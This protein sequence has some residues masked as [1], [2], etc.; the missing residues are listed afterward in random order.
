M[1]CGRRV[2]S[3]KHFAWV[4]LLL[5]AS[6]AAGD[7]FPVPALPWSPLRYVCARAPQAPTIDGRLDDP[8][9]REAAWTDP[10][11]D[12]EGAVRPDPRFLTRARMLWD[13]RYFY[14]AAE[15]E[16]PHVWGTLTERDAVIFRDN[17]FEVFLDPDGDTHEYYE[18]EINALG[19]EWDL[20]LIR[21]YR[22]GGPAVNAWDIQGLQTAVFIDGTINQPGDTDRGWSVEIAFPW[23]VLGQCAHRPAPPE[24]GDQWRVNFSRVEWDV[25]IRRGAYVKVV[26]E[27]TGEP[28]PEHNWVWSPQG[29]I[30][31][32]YPEMWGFVQFSDRADA[33]WIER[34]RPQ[35]AWQL[36]RAYYRQRQH[37]RDHGRYAGDLEALGLRAPAGWSY[38]WPPRIEVAGEQFNASLALPCGGRLHIGQDGRIW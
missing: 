19:T 22:D 23:S 26:D 17:D 2:R 36:R 28:H 8:A 27:A 14:V 32:H 3:L 6:V 11:V 18:L 37:Q 24:R 10:F 30:N 1:R 29:L 25:D 33:P 16:E 35:V 31:M 9:W 38:D 4:I 12:I 7:R 34:A 21:P 5:P 20:L 15:M 13:E